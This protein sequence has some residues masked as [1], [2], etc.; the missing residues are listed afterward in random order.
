MSVLENIMLPRFGMKGRLNWPELRRHATRLLDE[1]G[2]AAAFD[3]D[4]TVDTLSMSQRQMVEIFKALALDSRIIIFDEPT[5]S[6]SPM[7]SDRL[8]GVMRD[9]AVRDRGLIFVSHRLEEIFAATDRISVMREGRTV[10]KAL[11]TGSLDLGGLVRLMVGQELSDVYARRGGTATSGAGEMA[12]RVRHL[13]CPPM[14]RDVSFDVRHG[15]IVALAGLVGAGRSETV[16]TIFGLRRAT[17]GSIEL[18]GRP[19]SARQPVDAIRAGLG[20]IP[21]DR[22]RQGIVPDFSVREN[23]LLGHLGN[24]AGIGLAYDTRR[25]RV[26]G[27]LD[28]LGLPS[29][30]LLDASLLNFSGGMQQKIILARWLL[31]DPKVLLLDEPTRGVDIGTRSSIYALLRDIARHGIALVVVSSD[32]QEVIGLADRI[33]VMSDGITTTELPGDQVDME[34]LA[35][36]AAPR[37]SAERTRAL[38]AALAEEHGAVAYWIGAEGERIFCFQRVGVAPG[39]EPGFTGGG[40]TARAATAIPVALAAAGSGRFIAE[41]DGRHSLLVPIRGRRGHDFGMIGLTLPTGAPLP[42]AAGLCR[43]IAE[44]SDAPARIDA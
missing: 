2:Q 12:L 3:L 6:L 9:L 32:F 30:R 38:L 10:A 13:A 34:N 29:H 7:E 11:A 4:A 20:L 27:L 31:L 19:F 35:M 24:H 42:D 14:V 39:A 44:A 5:S 40:V 36:F 23:L 22:R 25:A 37:S 41:A 17:G 21:E 18:E 8:F 15:E 28:L 16:E 1:L 26:A 33:V 43:R